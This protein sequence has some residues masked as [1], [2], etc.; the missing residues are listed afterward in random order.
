MVNVAPGAVV[1]RFPYGK[2]PF[3]LL[4]VLLS[5]I[6]LLGF[7]RRDREAKPDL[8]FAIFA[9]NHVESYQE[10]VAAFEKKHDVKVALQLVH[11]AALQ[12]RLQNAMLAGTPVPDMVEMLEGGLGFFTRGPL[13]DVGFLDLTERLEDEGYRSRLVESRLSLWTMRKRVLALPHDVHPTVLVYQPA[14]VESRFDGTPRLVNRQGVA[15][16]REEWRVVDRWW[17]DE[18]VQRRYFELVLESGQNVVVF[19]DEER[20]GWFSQRGV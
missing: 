13:K 9:P 8:V 16:V 7:A 12:N 3:W 2:A 5:S 11:R 6:V 14:L 10:V 15:V 17:T 4:V 1:D 19:R 20:G 18:P